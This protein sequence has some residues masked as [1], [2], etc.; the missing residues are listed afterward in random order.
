[1]SPCRKLKMV[2]RETELEMIIT[3]W[4]DKLFSVQNTILELLE[5]LDKLESEKLIS[6][7]TDEADLED[8]VIVVKKEQDDDGKGMDE[9]MEHESTDDGW[10]DTQDLVEVKLNEGA[11]FSDSRDVNDSPFDREHHQHPQSYGQG[12]P[13][14][15]QHLHLHSQEQLHVQNQPQEL[16]QVH[17]QH[18][19]G[20]NQ[21]QGQMPHQVHVNSHEHQHQYP[22][23]Q[24]V[25]QHHQQGVQETSE[26]FNNS[27]NTNES[28]YQCEICDFSTKVKFTLNRH[29][30]LHE[31]NQTQCEKCSYT[32]NRMDCMAR[33]VKKH[34]NQPTTQIQTSFSENTC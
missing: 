28:Q 20:F 9:G 21:L 8:A 1:M 4:R 33:H 29:M 32:S 6:S 13:Q 7:E 12:H 15:H 26:Y 11:N 30:K 5:G 24:P 22:P 19:H 23:V 27:Q 10:E 3:S 16:H 34:H 18:Q 17:D 25:Q 14:E 31:D 2:G